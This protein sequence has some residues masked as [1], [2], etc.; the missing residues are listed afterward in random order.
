MP[1]EL[2]NATSA[3]NGGLMKRSVNLIRKSMKVD[4][5]GRDLHVYVS[6]GSKP[7]AQSVSGQ[8]AQVARRRIHANNFQSWACGAEEIKHQQCTGL[9]IVNPSL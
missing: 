1:G 8:R 5:G 9:N 3:D 2:T 4:S 7:P 6:A